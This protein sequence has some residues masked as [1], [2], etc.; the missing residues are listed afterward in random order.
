MSYSGYPRPLP[1]LGHNGFLA[2]WLTSLN[3]SH[4]GDIRHCRCIHEN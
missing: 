4:E 3:G 2:S 1:S